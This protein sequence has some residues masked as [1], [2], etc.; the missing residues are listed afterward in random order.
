MA[1]ENAYELAYREAVRALEHQRANL[2]ELRGRASMLLAAASITL[3]LL[4]HRVVHA[5]H[6]L[7]WMV[8]V[9]FA[10]LSLSVLAIVWPHEDWSVDVNPQALISSRLSL[11]NPDLSLLSLELIAHMA[12]YQQLNNR[13][14]RH[15]ARMFRIGACLLAMQ[16]VLTI[17]AATGI[18]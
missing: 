1:L 9:C 18:V 2:T 13:R 14:L 4:G 12:R 10:L 7:G 8:L 17:A 16:I 3:S 15:V 5:P 11:R 6:A